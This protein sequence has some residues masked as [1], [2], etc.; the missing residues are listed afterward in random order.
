MNSTFELGFVVAATGASM[1]RVRAQRFEG[2]AIDGRSVP[3]GGLWFALRGDRFDGH[4]FAA[5]AAAGGAA[6]LVVGRGRAGD[7]RGDP[8]VTV[9]EVDDP[10]VALGALARAHRERLPSLRVVG[11]TGSNGKTTTKELVAA[12]LAAHVGDAAVHKTAGN[13]NNHLGLPLTLLALT[14][15]HRFAVIEMG[16][17]A[18]GEIALL[19]S[20]A[21]PEIGV[22]VNVGPV[23]LETLGSIAEV[24]RAKGELFAALTPSGT[25]VFPDGDPLIAAEAAASPAVRRIRF[26]VRPGVEVRIESAR[27]LPEGTDVALRLPNGARLGARLAAVGGHHAMNAAAAAAVAFALDVPP[28][29]IARGLGA[30][31]SEKHRSSLIEVVGRRVLDDCYNAS[32]LSMAA[33]LETLAAIRGA[34]RAVAVLGDMLELGAEEV[35]LH[36]NIGALAARLG[37]DLLVTVGDHGRHIADGALSAGMPPARVRHAAT[38]DEAADEAARVAEPGDFILVKASRGMRLER[39]LE[40]LAVRFTASQQNPGAA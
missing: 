14:E 19:A 22:I 17:S 16:M 24:A 9:L 34:A 33:A 7:L 6:G 10:A 37:L 36:R 1:F 26:G 12:I 20:L 2:V 8:D 4:D 21:R 35:V 38:T 29:V 3:P 15:A 25:A 13:F 5:Q 18:R 27:A 30:A 31:R 39:V 40:A 11:V 28:S 32:P 23:H